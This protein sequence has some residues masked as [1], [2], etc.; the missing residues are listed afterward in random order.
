MADGG[1]WAVRCGSLTTDQLAARS[2]RANRGE[3]SPHPAP[4]GPS[5]QLG[6]AGGWRWS[7]GSKLVTGPLGSVAGEPDQRQRQLLCPLPWPAAEVEKDVE[8]HQDTE[9]V[10]FAG[11]RSSVVCAKIPR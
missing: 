1:P 6:W 5:G 2:A 7:R 10:C 8:E 3:L 9:I 11:T 4:H